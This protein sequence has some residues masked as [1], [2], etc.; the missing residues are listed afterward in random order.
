[1]FVVTVSFML[2]WFIIYHCAIILN[3]Q[4]CFICLCRMHIKL[5][6]DNNIHNMAYLDP[7]PVNAI[8]VSSK[9]QHMEDYLVTFLYS[10]QRKEC[11]FLPYN[12]RYIFNYAIIL[13]YVSLI[14]L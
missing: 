2:I 1:M 6:D 8:K 10:F 7:M 3:V 13:Y 11:I 4:T 5:C 9:P 14:F 12:F